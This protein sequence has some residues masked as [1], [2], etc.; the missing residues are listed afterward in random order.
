MPVCL[1]NRFRLDGEAQAALRLVEGLN[2][3]E[4]EQLAAGRPELRLVS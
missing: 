4:I 1:G 3:R 2:V